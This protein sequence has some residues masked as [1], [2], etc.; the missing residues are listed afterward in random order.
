VTR[1]AD[2]KPFT[3]DASKLLEIGTKRHGDTRL[4]SAGRSC[5]TCHSEADSYNATFKK[6]WPHFVASERS[7]TGLDRITAEGMVLFCMISAMGVR[8]LPWDS[9]TLAALT[10]F[11]IERHSKVVVKYLTTCPCLQQ[12]VGLLQQAHARPILSE[13]GA[14][15]RPK[16]ANCERRAF[17]AG[18]RD[19]L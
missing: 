17:C 14:S 9:E 19:Q 7:K 18:F 16:A 8:P 1:P 13:H 11:V 15:D 12:A 3:G 5:N 4:S 2:T 6:P 10:A